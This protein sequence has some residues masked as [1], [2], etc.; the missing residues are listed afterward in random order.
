MKHC[1]KILLLILVVLL[2]AAMLPSCSKD[3]EEGSIEDVD[4]EQPEEEE[5][6]SIFTKID[7]P[8]DYEYTTLSIKKAHMKMDVPASWKTTFVNSRYIVM[9][10][11]AEDEFLPDTTISI[12]CGYGENVDADEASEY[13]MNDHAYM[14]SEFFQE[15]LAGLP[16]CTG[17]KVRHLRKYFA[18]D[19]INNGLEFVD[20]DHEADVATL[21]TD[22]VTVVDKSMNYYTNECAMTTTYV[23]WDHT[24]FC[25][26]CI[27]KQAH[28]KNARSIMEYMV[29]SIVYEK[30]SAEGYKDVSYEDDFSTSVPMSFEPVSGAENVYVSSLYENTETAGMSVG[31]F[32]L[33]GFTKDEVTAENTASVYSENI[34]ARAFGGYQMNA[35]YIT[36]A[37]VCDEKDG[38]DF[39]GTVIVD[40]TNYSEPTEVAG[41]VFG[42]MSYY[43]ADYYVTESDGKAY[44]VSVIYQKCQKNLARAI[45]KNA[46]RKLKVK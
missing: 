43:L 8:Y 6:E 15:E 19:E 33:D 1:K 32:V 29:S 39:T 26:N 12:L 23:K 10:T 40:C 9:Q 24:P 11:P 4:I 22:E 2:A 5:A 42:P 46:V 18:E 13:T 20:P 38:P 35:S 17:G 16:T 25:F 45:G 30:P 14:F 37:D 27:S 44:L 31:V 3:A 36:S 28:R 34:A 7:S 21:V 41:S